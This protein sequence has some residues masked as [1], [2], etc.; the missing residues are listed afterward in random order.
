M[1]EWRAQYLGLTT[2]PAHLTAGEIDEIFTLDGDIAR[3]VAAR[4]KPLTRLGL[5]L[6]IGF[7]RLT[8]RALNSVQMIPP[9]VLERAGQAA[10]ISA[11][12]LASIRSIY[13][14]RM[15]LYQHQQAAMSA[16]GFRDYGE[17]CERALT[18]HL[19]RIATQSFDHAA[20]IGQAKAWLYDHH[21]VLPGQSRIEDRVAAAQAHVTKAIRQEMLQGAGK[22]CVQRWVQA[23]SAI[24]DEASGEALFEW[25]RKPV[26]GISQANIAEVTQRLDMLRSLGADKLS[27]TALPIAGMR[28][29]A[30]GMATQKVQTLALLREPRRTAEIGCWLRLQ[31]LQ[32]NDVALEQISRRIGELWRE[33]HEE[34]ET[35]A[36]RELEIYRAGVNAI[37]RALGDPELS[38]AALRTEVATVIAPLPSAVIGTGRAQ[39]VRAEMAARPSRL[40]S[41][42]K[43]VSGL[44]L[45][46]ADDHPVGIAMA[47]LARAYAS[48]AIGLAAA[49]TPFATAPRAL[50]E[51]AVTAEERLAAY[52]VATAL[53]FKRSLRNGAASSQHSIKHRSL[54][55]QLMPHA[56]WIQHKGSFA[57]DQALPKS[58]DTYLGG[59]KPILASQIAAL[60][61]AITAGDIGLRDDR[62]QIPKLKA[63][64]ES[65]EVRA[66]RRALFGAI[67]A[68]QLP[69]I[70]IEIDTRTHFSWILLGRQPTSTTELTLVY[71]A[72]LALGTMQSAASVSRMVAGVSDDQIEN[73]MHQIIAGGQPRA[74]SDAIVKYML[75]HPVA[76]RWGTGNQ[77]SADMMS[78][79]A[80]RHLWNARTE[81][82][83]GT[84][85]IGTYSHVLDQWPIIYDQAIV[86]NTRQAGVAIEGVLQQQL[87]SLQRLA[88]DTHG[89]TH[90]A[91]GLAKILGFDLCPR[92][93]GFSGRKLYLPR[94]IPVPARLE[95]IVERVPLG[96]SARGG[97]EGL[98]H[99]AASLRSG[100]GSA[101]TIIERHGS[102]ARGSPVYECGTLVGKVMRSV[103]MLDYLTN[104][105]FRREIH[106]LLAQGESL[107]ALQRAL[108]TGRIEAKHGRSEDDANAIS[109]ALTLLTNV[110]LAWN[111]AAMQHVIDANPDRYPPAQLAHIAPVAHR[112]INMKGV[113][114]FTIEPHHQLVRSNDRKVRK[115]AT[116]TNS[117]T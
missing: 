29:Y 27:L 105:E 53:L 67:G 11:P 40:R 45:A 61:A 33:A 112:H 55:D 44:N 20:L 8:G 49:S 35:R 24:Q 12:Q 54:A 13:R 39:A 9:A 100:Y 30:R 109:G 79:D 47:V 104:P 87:A 68:V 7:L 4:R 50:I 77:A 70:L 88:V 16:L 6:H 89:F 91:L 99:I 82:R 71:C 117:I 94:G 73:V 103:F 85:A 38:D 63:L 78:L 31:Y 114:R 52:E 15:T 113:M 1:Q 83:R 116:P 10:G 62:L 56:Q 18:G 59:Y 84:K 72:L 115:A 43:A 57:R 98:Q 3:I 107:H 51:A 37:R 65:P 2:F 108:L 90:F 101:A 60:D 36:F 76:R 80:T 46:Y 102:A 92:L 22:Q 14:R 81:P 111:T 93:A 69:D 5:V 17:A 32:L 97:W 66:T 74:A 96:R 41:L 23:L 19:R 48:Q 42:L 25:L 21:W 28:H 75:G 34:V 110:V 86:L 106:R 26:A 64:G 95:P 58:L